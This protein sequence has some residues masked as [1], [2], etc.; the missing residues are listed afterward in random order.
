[1][2]RQRCSGWSRSNWILLF[3]VLVGAALR[4][5]RLG[6][7]SLWRDEALSALIAASSSAE[8]LNNALASVH[9]PGYFFLLHLW[10]F[11]AGGTD[12]ALRYPSAFLG[13]LGIVLTF[14]L[15][16]DIR[17]R[18]LGLWAAGIMTLSP[19]HVFYSQEVRMYALLYCIT[20]VLMLAYIRLW[21]GGRPG[22]WALFA[23]TSMFG[24]WTHFFTGFVV[25]V[26]GGHFFLL[27]LASQRAGDGNPSPSWTGFFVA[28]G[29]IALFLGLYWPRFLSRAQLVES[30]AWRVRPSFGELVGLPLAFTTSQFLSGVWQIVALVCVMFLV[31]VVGLQVM[32]AL[33]RREPATDWLLLLVLLFLAPVTI[34]FVLSQFWKSIFV[35]RVLIVVAPSFYLLIAWSAA[36]T[37]E[38][39][40]NQILVCLLLLLMAVGVC[41]WFFDPAYAKPPVRDAVSLVQESERTGAPVIHAIVTSCIIFEHYAPDLNN[42]LLAD[43]LLVLWPNGVS[44]HEGGGLVDSAA[45]LDDGF[46]FI[47]FPIH[48]QEFQLARRDDLDARFN[49]EQEWDVGGIQIYY[50]VSR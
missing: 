25:A 49:R 2:I 32:R 22:W 27:R 10:R 45:V 17:S 11:A 46:W 38:H 30:E 13:V 35:A 29:V 1:M 15:G 5:Y 37:H 21:Q 40:L 36:H 16:R 48:S 6:A 19:F 50:Y 33:W 41:N 23:L 39:R 12:L 3:I 8:V 4:L 34:T 24:L 42:R 9:P 47:V 14:Q 28:N 43:T 7:Q 26:L 20:C 44:E 31:I 18:Q